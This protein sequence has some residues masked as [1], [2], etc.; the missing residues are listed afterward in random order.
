MNSP[1]GFTAAA[2]RDLLVVGVAGGIVAGLVRSE[3]AAASFLLGCLWLALNF[4]LLA[5]ILSMFGAANR[6]AG[7]FVFWLVCAKIPASYFLLYWLYAVDYLDTAG[8]TAG[9]LVLPLV[10]VY[11]GLAWAGKSKIEEKDS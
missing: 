3:A 11:R 9:L 7:S 8:L 6:P 5:W 10:L 2:V 1:G 4:T